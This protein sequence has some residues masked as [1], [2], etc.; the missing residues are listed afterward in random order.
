MPAG[1]DRHARD[2]SVNGWNVAIGVGRIGKV[3]DQAGSL[4]TR[5][6]LLPGQLAKQSCG[7]L[8]ALAIA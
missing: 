7:R 3:N 1:D 8:H 6:P 2:V 5:F 4:L